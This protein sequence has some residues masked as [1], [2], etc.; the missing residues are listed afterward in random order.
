MEE[1]FR[2]NGAT[3]IKIDNNHDIISL[4]YADDLVIMGDSYTDIKKKLDLLYLYC[5]NNELTVNVN[6]TKILKLGLGREPKKQ[7]KFY[8][9]NQEIEKVKQFDYLGITFSRSGQFN[10]TVSSSIAKANA[11]TGTAINILCKGKSNS[12]KSRTYL[13]QSLVKSCLLYCCPVWALRHGDQLEKVQMNYYKRLL[14]LPRTTPNH[15]IRL[16]TDQLKLSFNILKSTLHWMFKISNSAENSFLYLCFATLVNYS[17]LKPGEIKYNWFSQ[18]K[19]CLKCISIDDLGP[20]QE[21]VRVKRNIKITL[22]RYKNYL[23]QADLERVLKSSFNIFWNNAVLL[24]ETQK[25]LQSSIPFKFIKI[26]AQI[27]LSGPYFIK[28]TLNKITYKINPKNLCLL[29]NLNEPETLTHIF[30][31]CPLY[32]LFRKQLNITA[33]NDASS[34]FTNLFFNTPFEHTIYRIYKFLENVLKLRA[35]VLNE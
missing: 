31:K 4:G 25:Y 34:E 32:K 33:E 21:L 9:N 22:E 27:R 20:L 2:S 23:I 19:E 7:R 6:K 5:I 8:F 24:N 13:F 3:G 1:Y 35:F 29:C 10:D 15:L 26:Y 28:L 18:A 14:C 11:A 17:V 16:E 12:W 30:I